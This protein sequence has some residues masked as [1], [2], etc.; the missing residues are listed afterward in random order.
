MS[1]R[2]G[3]IKFLD[4]MVK[5]PYFIVRAHYQIERLDVSSTVWLEGGLNEHVL[6]VLT[7]DKQVYLVTTDSNLH[8]G[9]G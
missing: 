7:L 4:Y 5:V 8:H 1:S 9:W 2:V 6:E 3:I